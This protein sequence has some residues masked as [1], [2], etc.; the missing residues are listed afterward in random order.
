MA[1]GRGHGRG[2]G[3]ASNRLWHRMAS[4]RVVSR[5]SHDQ[6]CL[7]TAVRRGMALSIGTRGTDLAHRQ[8]SNGVGILSW[9]AANS[10]LLARSLNAD[11]RQMHMATN[12]NKS[13]RTVDLPPQPDYFL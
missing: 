2:K 6:H 5:R 1:S 10:D 9:V 4:I 8:R 11:V 12:D 13:P 3:Q 7:W